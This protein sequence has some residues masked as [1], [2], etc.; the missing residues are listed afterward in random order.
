MLAYGQNRVGAQIQ[1][2]LLDLRCIGQH[3]RAAFADRD[4][5]VHP[6]RDGN[7]H[8]ALGF[9]NDLFELQRNP[10][11]RLV[12]AE[13]QNL[14]HQIA[15]TAAGFVDFFQA[16]QRVRPRRGVLL[17]QV[18][19]AQNRAQDVV[20]IMGNTAGHGAHRLHFLRLAQ[21]GFQRNTLRLGQLL[22]GQVA[23]KNSGDGALP[24]GLSAQGNRVG[25]VRPE[26]GAGAQ[27]AL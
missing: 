16:D 13:G 27:A 10:F 5:Q 22:G 19:I 26:R 18:H 8:Q 9:L 15:R 20:E 1:Q 7:P 14:A 6:R 11:G 2:C 21:L 23:G 17:G 4:P 25:I 24:A 12:A 3:Q